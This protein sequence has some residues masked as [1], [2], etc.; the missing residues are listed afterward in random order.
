[1]ELSGLLNLVVVNVYVSM[2]KM[3]GLK[4]DRKN[5]EVKEKRN[6]VNRQVAFCTQ[7]P[8]A[9][10]PRPGLKWV[11]S[12]TQART[13]SLNQELLQLRIRKPTRYLILVLKS[14]KP[15]QNKPSIYSIK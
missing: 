10:V 2:D 15:C 3:S 9:V 13:H 14:L 8:A 4:S 12:G 5:K 6:E 11:S 1:M 7:A